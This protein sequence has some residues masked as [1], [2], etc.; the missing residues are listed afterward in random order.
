MISWWYSNANQETVY[1]FGIVSLAPGSLLDRFACGPGEQQAY[2]MSFFHR[3][4]WKLCK[5]ASPQNSVKEDTLE[6][7]ML[8]WPIESQ[9]VGM[10]VIQWAMG[11]G[12]VTFARALMTLQGISS[13]HK[14]EKRLHQSFRHLFFLSVQA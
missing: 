12:T 8:L 13:G 5:Q 7:M 14:I 2:Q 6:S 9:S 10:A 3:P 4:G 11:R 1:A